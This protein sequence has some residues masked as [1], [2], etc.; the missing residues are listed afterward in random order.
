MKGQKVNWIVLFIKIFVVNL[1]FRICNCRGNIEIWTQ[2]NRVHRRFKRQ[3][4]H[5]VFLLI[6]KIHTD[7]DKTLVSVCYSN[8]LLWIQQIK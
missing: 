1:C 3:N 5:K 7:Q 8:F 6:F 4:K 2:N